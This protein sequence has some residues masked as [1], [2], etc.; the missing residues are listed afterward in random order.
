MTRVSSMRRDAQRL[1]DIGAS[2][3][4]VAGYLAE[5]EREQFVS[6]GLAQDAILRQLMVA[7]EAAF[8]I[9]AMTK[10]RHPEI[11]RQKSSDFGIVSCMI[12]SSLT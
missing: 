2:T 3:A 8:R 5:I 1:L 6:G 10:D 4:I 11:P 9:S 7:G 12:I